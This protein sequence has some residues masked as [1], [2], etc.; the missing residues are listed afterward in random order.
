MAKFVTGD[1][2]IQ[3][4]D[5]IIHEAKERLLIVS[6]F[7]RLD[8]YF[9]DLFSIH[10]GN[11]DVEIILVFGKNEYDVSR[12][13]QEEDF[14]FFKSFPNIGIVYVPNLHAKYFSNEK[15][16]VVTSINLL[17]ASFKNNIEYG[18]VGEPK[19]FG[20]YDKFDLD[21]FHES[22]DVV[23]EGQAVFARVPSF[24]KKMFGLAK[25][26]MG[27]EIVW[28]AT[29][30]LLNGYPFDERDIFEFMDK[31][32]FKEFE[33][34]LKPK[35]EDYG[36]ESR[37]SK[38]KKR[39]QDDQ[40]EEGYCIRCETEI[41]YDINRPYCNKCYKIWSQFN[42]PDYQEQVCHSCGNQEYTSME[43]PECYSC[44]KRNK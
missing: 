15:L 42:N 41:P 23:K 3:A 26:Y 9:K 32:R 36:A 30:D 39:D 16:G 35:R 18:V 1:D 44:Y 10:K 8:G 19:L 4:V 6:P 13:L 5:N 37:A 17:D 22:L 21:A 40:N 29:Q 31:D 38:I 12:S 27:S 7:I 20:G 2:L 11:P 43:K 28:D 34:K 14:E 24:K 33:T 25:D